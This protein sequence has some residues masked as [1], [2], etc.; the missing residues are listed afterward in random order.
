M[1]EKKRI[2]PSDLRPWT[3]DEFNKIPKLVNHF[4]TYEN[5]TKKLVEPFLKAKAIF[6]EIEELE[7]LEK[8]EEYEPMKLIGKEGKKHE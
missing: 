2:N 6:E 5:Y 7:Q 8:I 4:G 3:E 1:N